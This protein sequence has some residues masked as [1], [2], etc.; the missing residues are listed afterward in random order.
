MNL[1]KLKPPQLAAFKGRQQRL[2]RGF[3]LSC[4]VSRSHTCIMSQ[5]EPLDIAG[6]MHA[7]SETDASPS[8]LLAGAVGQLSSD[9][10]NPATAYG[11]YFSYQR[12]VEVRAPES[13]EISSSSSFSSF[14]KFA[15][16]F[17]PGSKSGRVLVM[18]FDRKG[19]PTMKEM[20]RHEVL[21]MTQEATEPKEEISPEES[22]SPELGKVSLPMRRRSSS[23]A[24]KIWRLSQQNRSASQQDLHAPVGVQVSWCLEHNKSRDP[25]LDTVC[26]FI[27]N[28]VFMLVTF[29]KWRM[30]SQ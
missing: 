10:V 4:G 11:T 21:R 7:E 16:Q 6:D 17:D 9:Y 8:P 25:L 15:C 3:H 14:K 28:S 30:H 1:L 20:S 24:G 5:S 22:G 13:A 29:A 12:M 18:I 2:D 27:V 19:R 23:T 26:A